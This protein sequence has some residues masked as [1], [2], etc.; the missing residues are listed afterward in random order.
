M[1][2]EPYRK[3]AAM[4]KPIVV[5]CNKQSDGY[6]IRLNPVSAATFKPD[7]YRPSTIFLEFDFDKVPTLSILQWKILCK[8]LFNFKRIIPCIVKQVGT[9]T[10]YFRW[11]HKTVGVH[12]HRQTTATV[13]NTAE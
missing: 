10:V 13:S 3:D 2:V 9:R 11:P 8:G 1:G 5:D 4:R 12:A 6:C 7:P